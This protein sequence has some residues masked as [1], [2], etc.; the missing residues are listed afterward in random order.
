MIEFVGS[1]SGLARSTPCGRDLDLVK[2]GLR[3]PH[4]LFKSN[5]NGQTM[6]FHHSNNIVKSNESI[7]S[8]RSRS[9]FCNLARFYSKQVRLM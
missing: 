7:D 9:K 2:S 8:S 3:S 5:L 1:K 4:I 6:Y